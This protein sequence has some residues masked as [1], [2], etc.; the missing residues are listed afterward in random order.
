[1]D[2][3]E[4]IIRKYA[5]INATQHGGQ[6][7]PGAVIGMIMSKHPEYRQNAGEVSKTAAQIVQTVNQM[8]AEDQNQELEDRGGYQEKK[9][10]RKRSRDWRIY[11][12]LMRA[13]CYVLPQIHQAP[14]I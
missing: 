3:L 14:S 10:N 7:Q 6:A 5:L 2:K 13:W 1:M 4:E 8:S 11:P 12:I 9:K